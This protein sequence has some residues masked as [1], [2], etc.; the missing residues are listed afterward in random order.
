MNAPQLRSD[1]IAATPRNWLPT[2]G[3]LQRHFYPDIVARDPVAT[4]VRRLDRLVKPTDEV[5]DLGAGAG[6]LNAY[7]LKGRVRRLVGIDLDPRVCANPLLDAGLRADIYALPFRDA[8]F[9][10]VFAI[11]VLEHVDRGAA[12]VAEIRRVL[13]PGGRLIVNTPHLKQS[14]LRRVRHALGQSDEKH[15]HLRPGYTI[16]GLSAM[17]EPD[18]VIR[19]QRTYSRFFSE[20]VDTALNWAVERTG[21][22]SSAKGLVVTSDDLAKSRRLFRLYSLVYPLVWAVTRLDALVPASGYMLIAAARRT[23]GTRGREPAPA[24]PAAGS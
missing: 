19:D 21:K 18:F 6:E 12:L 10:V 9:D 5:L 22:R 15:G 4:F 23:G 16:E 13:K 8:S 1:A 14:F 2:V 3:S 7:A 24:H 20:L 17:L 11:Y